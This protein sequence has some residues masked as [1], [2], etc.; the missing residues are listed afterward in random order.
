[1][2]QILKLRRLFIFLGLTGLF[3]VAGIVSV[4]MVMT[5][6]TVKNGVVY[7]QGDDTPY[8]VR[9]S[10]EG[11][12]KIAHQDSR[13]MAFLDKGKDAGEE[14]EIIKLNDD[15]PEPPPIQL[16]SKKEAE[17]VV[18][19]EDFNSNLDKTLDSVGEEKWVEEG[20]YADNIKDEDEERMNIIGQNGN[21]GLHYENNDWFHD[22]NEEEPQQT[23]SIDNLTIQELEELKSKTPKTH[24]YGPKGWKNI[25][26]R[27]D[28][29]KAGDNDDLIIKYN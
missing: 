9:P 14:A 21:E 6:L 12:Q 8:K 23:E 27:I 24:K 15:Q 2:L 16:E 29:L 26:K 3:I 5:P 1:M 11:G 7:I 19:E 18:V 10:E 17:E 22:E 28:E 25:Q 20:Y 4:F 13:F